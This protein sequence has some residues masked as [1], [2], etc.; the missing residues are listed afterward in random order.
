MTQQ[1]YRSKF[2]ALTGGRVRLFFPFVLIV[3]FL[4]VLAMLLKPVPHVL[5]LAEHGA[6]GYVYV[7]N[8]NVSSSNSITVF[9]RN[10]VGSLSLLRT[11]SI[12]GL[13]SVTAFADGT[14]G[15][16]IITHDERTRLF[17][18]DAGSDQISVLKVQNGHLSL[19]GVFA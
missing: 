8:N 14:Q 17:A 9:A 12:G 4:P 6:D 1:N 19:R 2:S 16:L 10:E 15:S 3:V 11:T 5:A 7:L 18:V 13:G